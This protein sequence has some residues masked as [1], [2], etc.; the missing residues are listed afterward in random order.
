MNPIKR[1]RET[2]AMDR[3]TAATNFGMSYAAL[4]SLELGQAAKLPRA[5][6]EWLMGEQGWSIAQIRALDANYRS[7]QLHHADAEAG[8]SA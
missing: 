8:E 3:V 2:L 6:T 4:K 5:L 1:L 7:W